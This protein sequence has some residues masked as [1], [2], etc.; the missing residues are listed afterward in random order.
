MTALEYF[1]EHK[2][3]LTTDKYHKCQVDVV[4]KNLDLS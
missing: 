4:N 2:D 3:S 1:R